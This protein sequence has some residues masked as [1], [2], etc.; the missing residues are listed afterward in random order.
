MKTINNLRQF[1]PVLMLA[2]AMIA[3]TVE[4]NAQNRRSNNRNNESTRNEYKSFDRSEKKTAQKDWKENKNENR[5]KQN[6]KRNDN[7]SEYRPKYS[8]RMKY[9]QP[10]YFNH[11]KYGRVYSRF[12]HNPVVF[13]NDRHD[14][15]YYGNNFYT[16]RRGVGYCVTQPPRSAYFRHLPMECNRVNINGQVFF[17][18]GDLYFQ[19]SPR[20]YAM[21][22]APMGIRISARF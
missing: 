14:Y 2:T 10:D 11:P 15:Y 13:R 19:L 4:V 21:V 3:S 12:D 22:S 9:N 18:N 16:Y 7:R 1:I 20:G 6:W 8:S 17:R 5:E